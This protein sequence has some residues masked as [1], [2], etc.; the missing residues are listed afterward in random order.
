MEKQTQEEKQTNEKTVNKM[1]LSKQFSVAV[2][3]V[4]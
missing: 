4:G 1:I 2:C 3:F